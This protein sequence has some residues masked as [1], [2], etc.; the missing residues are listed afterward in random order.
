MCYECNDHEHLK[1]ECPKYLRGKG[2]MF[3]TTLSDSESLNSVTDGECDSEGN[4]RAFMA[5]TSI[6]SK[7]DLS[8]LVDELGDHFEGEEVED[9]KDEEVC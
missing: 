2:K 1:K 8:N 4:Y 6:D 9:S 5:I 3:S 7:D